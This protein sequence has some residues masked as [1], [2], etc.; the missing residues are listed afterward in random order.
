ML[1]GCRRE[2]ILT[3]FKDLLYEGICASPLYKREEKEARDTTDAVSM[4]I[5]SRENLDATIMIHV[6]EWKA[7]EIVQR[8]YKY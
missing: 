6:G 7:T 1:R 5:P 8:I 2:L 4:R 3:V